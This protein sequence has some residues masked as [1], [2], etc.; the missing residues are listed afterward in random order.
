MKS[1]L[2]FL[3]ALVLVLGSAPSQ[4]VD[5]YY[6]PQ[7]LNRV[8]MLSDWK[9]G[10]WATLFKCNMYNLSDDADP[11]CTMLISSYPPVVTRLGEH[12]WQVSFVP[13]QTP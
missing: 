1:A 13:P 5:W 12:K 7:V 6:K 2:A 9:S 4:S 8:V 3:F 11:R 10:H